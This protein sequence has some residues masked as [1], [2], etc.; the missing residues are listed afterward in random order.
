MGVRRKEQQM[1]TD[2]RAHVLGGE[3]GAARR[4][5]TREDVER[6]ERQLREHRAHKLIKEANE[7][8]ARSE[9]SP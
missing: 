6:I 9:P 5:G 2:M 7:L 8:L 1:A 4:W 3:L